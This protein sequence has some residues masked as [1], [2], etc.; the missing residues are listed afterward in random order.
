MDMVAEEVLSIVL[1]RLGHVRWLHATLAVSSSLKSC[2]L[3]Y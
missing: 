3:S 2:R 1:S